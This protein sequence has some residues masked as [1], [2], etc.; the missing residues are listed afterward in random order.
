MGLR[1]LLELPQI[2]S[3]RTYDSPHLLLLLLAKPRMTAHQVE[4]GGCVPPR[5]P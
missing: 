3:R 4:G 5:S 1:L 2:E